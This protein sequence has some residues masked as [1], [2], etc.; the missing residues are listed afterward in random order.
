VGAAVV[1]IPSS[2]FA[3]GTGQRVG[4]DWMAERAATLRSIGQAVDEL[5]GL[6]FQLAVASRT[7]TELGDD[8]VDRIVAVEHLHRDGHSVDGSA[9]LDDI[10]PG[11]DA[12]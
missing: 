6:G 4:G 8:R 1:V 3:A 7:G 9:A 11:R 10:L 12:A 5:R 2:T